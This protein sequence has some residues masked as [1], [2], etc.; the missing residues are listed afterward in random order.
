[1]AKSLDFRVAGAGYARAREKNP[2]SRTLLYTDIVRV[3]VLHWHAGG[4]KVQGDGFFLPLGAIHQHR[5]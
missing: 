3:S 1:M 5:L 4:Y 2:L